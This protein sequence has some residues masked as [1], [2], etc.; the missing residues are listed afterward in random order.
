M[1]LR[2]LGGIAHLA[3]SHTWRF[4]LSAA[5]PSRRHRPLGGIVLWTVWQS[6]GV[7]QWDARLSQLRRPGHRPERPKWLRTKTKNSS[8]LEQNGL[9][10]HTHT[11][12]HRTQARAQRHTHI[13]A[14][15]PPLLQQQ[16]QPQQTA[17]PTATTPT[18][19]TPT[20]TTAT[21]DYTNRN[22]ANNIQDLILDLFSSASAQTHPQQ[23]SSLRPY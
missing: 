15:S 7:P 8:V 5:S 3:E 14:H 17:T 13:H 2:P 20:A 11:H 16:Q 9:R 12:T 23:Q 1:A 22:Y 19:T 4:A 18:T 10:T 6:H 21:H